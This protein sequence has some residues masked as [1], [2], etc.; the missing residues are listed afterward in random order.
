MRTR[1]IIRLRRTSRTAAGRRAQAQ[2]RALGAEIRQLRLD[3]GISQR[4]LALAAGISQ[5]FLCQIEDG[6]AE[7][8]LS[9]LWA[10]AHALGAELSVRLFPNTGPAIQDRHQARM[11]EALLSASHTS[12]KRLVEV[13]VSFPARGSI[14][15]V[16]VRGVDVIAL[17]A[18]SSLRRLEQQIRRHED[19][20]SS[21]PSAELWRF[22]VDPD[23]PAPRVHRLLLLR[24]THAT[25]ETT[26]AFAATMAAA[27]PTRAADLHAALAGPVTPWPGS[28][29]L[30]VD[31]SGE[32][33]RILDRP[34]RGVGLGR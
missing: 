23:G 4:R 21:L 6:E 9:V 8:S 12:W 28:G 10:I 32:S 2:R 26:R 30:W 16:L 27:Y 15:A 34:P 20:A 5:G 31:V 7:P 24:S 1:P 18:E 19:K 22:A 14:D 29:I 17:E 11:I 33:A 25:R 13:P 3:A